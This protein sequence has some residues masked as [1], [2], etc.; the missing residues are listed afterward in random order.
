[1]KLTNSNK[2]Y[3]SPINKSIDLMKRYNF[4]S[5][6]RSPLVCG[7]WAILKPYGLQNH[8]PQLCWLNHNQLACVW[9][10]GNQEGECSMSIIISILNRG[11]RRWTN[12]KCI[13][14]DNQKSEQNPFL[15][16]LENG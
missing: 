5:L 12:S 1:M 9:M 4:G 15:F 10:S 3:F 13:S 11:S 7:Y 2:D 6:V 14:Q 8:A 16:V